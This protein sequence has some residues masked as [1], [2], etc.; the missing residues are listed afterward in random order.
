MAK[1][2][3]GVVAVAFSVFAF[4]CGACGG[5]PF[6]ASVQDTPITAL[7][8]TTLIEAGTA[9]SSEDAGNVQDTSND[10]DS[11]PP[12]LAEAG[13]LAEAE[14][15]E[16]GA[17]EAGGGL[18]DAGKGDAGSKSDADDAGCTPLAHWDGYE[19]YASCDALSTDSEADAWLACEAFSADHGLSS[20]ANCAV[21]A[22]SDLCTGKTDGGQAVCASSGGTTNQPCW[23]Y[24][25]PSAGH[26]YPVP[27][28]AMTAAWE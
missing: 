7:P 28:C 19:D 4:A 25:G 18:E 10:A 17:V 22:T 5:A 24:A 20:S 1:R 27:Y 14:S 26:L 23:V 3:L 15:A 6:T 8:G 9:P 16:A 13:A 21:K 12:V 2:G 11:G